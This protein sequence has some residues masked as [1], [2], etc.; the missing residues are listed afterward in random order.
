MEVLKKFPTFL[1]FSEGEGLS[2]SGVTPVGATVEGGL[3]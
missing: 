3:W 1:P 2:G